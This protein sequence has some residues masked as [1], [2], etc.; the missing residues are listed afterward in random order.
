MTPTPL[1]QRPVFRV[2]TTQ[3]IDVLHHIALRKTLISGCI[4]LITDHVALS[5]AQ[6]LCSYHARFLSQYAQFITETPPPDIYFFYELSAALPDLHQIFHETSLTPACTQEILAQ[7]PDTTLEF[8]E[9]L[10]NSGKSLYQITDAQAHK[11]FDFSLIFDKPKQRQ[12]DIVQNW[13]HQN[14]FIH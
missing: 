12:L 1:S 3:D 11:I 9:K 2:S 4:C 5:W 10:Q 6:A 8:Q 14:Q 7:N 13:L